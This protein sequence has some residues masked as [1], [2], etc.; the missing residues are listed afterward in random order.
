[1]AQDFTSNFSQFKNFPVGC[2]TATCEALK[3][4]VGY[5]KAKV[6][7]V[8]V[9]L[10]YVFQIEY[11]K[12]LFQ[13]I[14]ARKSP[15]KRLH[16]RMMYQINKLC[17]FLSINYK[18]YSYMPTLAAKNFPLFLAQIRTVGVYETILF[19]CGMNPS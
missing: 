7:E 13:F 1:M 12:Y 14:F 17:H 18:I 10:L 11:V 2:L 4:F 19:E 8:R 6:S 16:W 9:V 5:T 3:V 15:V